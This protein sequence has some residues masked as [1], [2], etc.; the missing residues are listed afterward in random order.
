MTRM[1]RAATRT[2]VSFAAGIAMLVAACGGGDSDAGKGQRITDPA[3][4]PSSTP[5]QGAVVFQIRGD[6]V[7]TIG[8]PGGTVTGPTTQ[9]GPRTYT[10][11]AGDTCG[12]IATKNNVTLEDLLRTNR[13]V[14]P[15]CR[16][17]RVGDQLRIPGTIGTA[18]GT[19]TRGSGREHKVAAGDT[20]GAIAG[21][22][23]VP[24][25]RLLAANPSIDCSRLQIGQVVRIP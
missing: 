3:K 6:Q 12:S 18:I 23:G 15:D 8:G 1:V 11:V 9:A 14:D 2:L 21:S 20:C 17:L 5:I 10:V 13:N 7:S 19:P 24:L 22:F 25:D 4:V 16:N